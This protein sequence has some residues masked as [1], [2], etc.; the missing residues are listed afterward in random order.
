VAPVTRLYF[1]YF[2][3]IPDYAGLQFWVDYYKTGH[4]LE[5][6]SNAFANSP[7]FINTYGPLNNSQF[8]TLVYQNVLGRAPDQAGFDFY[9]NQL[10]TNQLTRGQVMLSFSESAEYIQRSYNQVYVT[11]MYVGM[12]RRS[13]DQAGFDF[14]VGWLAGGNSGLSLIGGFVTAPE[15][16][17]RFLP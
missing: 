8:V 7:E 14:W 10:N 13:P 11:M 15:Y 6:I 12:L 16:H 3:R 2:N 4:P 5:E 9:V 17:D 1:A